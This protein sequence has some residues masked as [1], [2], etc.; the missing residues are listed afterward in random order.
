M[1]FLTAAL[2]ALRRENESQGVPIPRKAN[3]LLMFP[4]LGLERPRG[5]GR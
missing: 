3:R 2:P 1:F 5:I 4:M